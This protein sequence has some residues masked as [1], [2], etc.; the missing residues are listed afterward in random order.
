MG[1]PAGQRAETG[2]PIIG[3]SSLGIYRCL[4]RFWLTKGISGS[5]PLFFLGVQF[6]AVPQT[7]A[8]QIK[9][10]PLRAGQHTAIAEIGYLLG[11]PLDAFRPVLVGNVQ[12]DDATGKQEGTR[13]AQDHTAE[14]KTIVSFA[15]WGIRHDEVGLPGKDG[16]GLL[17]GGVVRSVRVG[18]QKGGF[19]S[20]PVKG[21]ILGGDGDIGRVDV[22]ADEVGDGGDGRGRDA[23]TPVP[24]SPIQPLPLEQMPELPHCLQSDPAGR[25]QGKRARWLEKNQFTQT[26]C[27]GTVQ[28]YLVGH[29]WV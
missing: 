11:K 22:Q 17:V 16:Q 29:I 23:Q 13:P 10:N 24:T 19:V 21:G 26:T 2:A 6:Q 8:L 3:Q 4:G 5:T 25:C 7:R 28:N 12:E 1:L 20:H 14:R 18:Q 27:T 15:G 9:R